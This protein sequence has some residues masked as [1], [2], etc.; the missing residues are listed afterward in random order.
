MQDT[1]G[2]V[3]RG[4]LIIGISVIV[5][6]IGLGYLNAKRQEPEFAEGTTVQADK[7]DSEMT[8]AEEGITMQPKDQEAARDNTPKLEQ[9]KGTFTRQG[10]LLASDNSAR[11]NLMLKTSTSNFYFQ[12][13]RDYSALM[14]KSVT[15]T[16][17]GTVERFSLI[18]IT[19]NK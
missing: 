2:V 11:G 18:D 9:S 14:G 6:L 5:L 1:T 10:I 13:S 7:P 15:I 17:N 16:G 8:Q 12:T 4:R 19:T 3:N